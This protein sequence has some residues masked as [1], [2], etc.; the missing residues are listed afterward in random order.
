MSYGACSYGSCV[1][2]H[3]ASCLL[4]PLLQAASP[5]HLHDES[6]FHVVRLWPSNSIGKGCIG[7][8]VRWHPLTAHTSLELYG[9]VD[10]PPSEPIVEIK[11]G[12]RWLHSPST[13]VDQQDTVTKKSRGNGELQRKVLSPAM[14]MATA[15]VERGRSRGDAAAHPAQQSAPVCFLRSGVPGRKDIWCCA[16]KQYAL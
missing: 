12:L 9:P 14:R 5:N 11:L 6:S 1:I 10:A 16:G 7:C 2:S 15:G 8:S 3:W 4:P 13:S